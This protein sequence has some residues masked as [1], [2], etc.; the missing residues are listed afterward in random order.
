MNEGFMNTAMGLNPVFESLTQYG[1]AM[2]SPLYTAECI[3]QW[4]QAVDP[5]FL[6]YSS[7]K[8]P[9]IRADQLQELGLL[10]SIFNQNLKDLIKGLMPD[11]VL[12]HCHVYEIDGNQSKPH[13]HANNQLNGWHRDAECLYAA[14]PDEVHHFSFFVYLTDVDRK[15]GPFEIAPL[16]SF[17]PLK[18]HTPSIKVLGDKGSNFLFDRTFLHR[19]TANFSSSRRRVL[20]LSFQNNHLV[21]DR[22]HLPEFLSVRNSLNNTSDIVFQWF[23]GQQKRFNHDIK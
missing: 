4:N 11:A 21:N 8:R 13:I 10:D 5:W 15:N 1:L 9:Y 16:S 23:G 20:K 19:A 12:Y 22:I 2:L 7:N 3:E 18:N 6:K 17:Q 14:A